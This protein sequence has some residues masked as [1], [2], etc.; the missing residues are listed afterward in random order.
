MKNTEKYSDEISKTIQKMA[1]F[2]ITSGYSFEGH[3]ITEYYAP[4]C[5]ES[6]VGAL[7]G[8]AIFP[9]NK[10]NQYA[11]LDHFS[12]IETA[13]YSAIDRLLDRAAEFGANAVIGFSFQYTVV[14]K[15][16]LLVFASGTAVQLDDK[17]DEADE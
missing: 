4:V 12:A 6:L 14:G 7:V 9:P 11:Y 10:I 15:D 17:A 3:H 1:S 8:I 5:G 16:A 13:R 2:F